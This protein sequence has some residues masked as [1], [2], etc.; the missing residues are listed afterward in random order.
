MGNTI[1]STKTST[2]ESSAII[3]YPN[4]T[5]DLVFLE[6]T[7][8]SLILTPLK[9]YNS[10]GQFLKSYKSV[11]IVSEGVSLKEFSSG[12]YYLQIMINGKIFTKKI[13]KK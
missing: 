3:I 1:L 13:I 2:Y 7:N 8:S 11:D 5:Q 9:L 10:I 4:P 12:I 6:N